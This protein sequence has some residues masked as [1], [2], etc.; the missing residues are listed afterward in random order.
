[1][2]STARFTTP[3]AGSN[4]LIYRYNAD[5]NRWE[6]VSLGA[7]SVPDGSITAAKLAVGAVTSTRLAD[8]A[9]TPAKIAGAGPRDATAFYR[10]D[11]AWAVPPSADF[12]RVMSSLLTP[13][14]SSRASSDAQNRFELLP[15]GTMK[16][17]GGT[18]APGMVQIVPVVGNPVGILHIDAVLR[19]A[20]RIVL[21]IE[22]DA[23]VI[24]WGGGPPNG[25]V[26]AYPG[27]LYLQKDG[28]AGT[29]IWFKESGAGTSNG[30]VSRG[31]G[32]GGS[33]GLQ[34]VAYASSITPD[35]A[36]GEVVVVGT[37]TN[38]LT[39]NNPTV[40]TPGRMLEF[41]YQQDGSG[42]R[43][44]TYGSHFETPA[45]VDPTAGARSYQRFRCITSTLWV[46]VA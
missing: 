44:V 16:F 3:T 36:L 7:A 1:M 45:P 28:S 33:T 46:E 9:V 15:D 35:P 24:T 34:N 31:T 43:T 4:E 27:S 13:A 17:G 22:N 19:S 12:N 37:L 21:G 20:Y 14:L 39:V 5:L 18:T 30:W 8:N 38:N 41:H 2:S 6:L 42:N 29:S 11:G 23:P 25:G 10:G 40:S 26:F 32:S